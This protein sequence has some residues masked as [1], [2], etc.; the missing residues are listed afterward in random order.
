MSYT[1]EISRNNPSC[2]V[3]LIDRSGSMEDPFASGEP[4]RKKSDAV[5]DAM[6]RLLQNL[7]IKCAKDEGIR[8]YY[9][10][11]VIGYGAQTESAFGGPLAGRGF[12]PISEIGSSPAR[13]DERKKLIEDGAGGLVEKTVKFPVWFDAIAN[14]GTPM[15]EALGLAGQMLNDWLSSHADCFPPIVINITDGEATDGDPTLEAQKI[16]DLQSSDGHVLLFNLHCSSRK[17]SAIEYPN[18]DFEL[19]DAFAKQLFRLSSELPPH[20]Q[21]ALQQEG[22]SVSAGARGFVF[23]GGMESIIKFLDIGTRP[24]NLR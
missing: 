4:N 18:T 21:S 8:D 23:N 7:V 5:A 9:H 16:A 24:S 17:G 3:F 19:P 6:N 14:G 10:A 11:A 13:V 1:A 15:C 12:V 22:L 20:M 2:F